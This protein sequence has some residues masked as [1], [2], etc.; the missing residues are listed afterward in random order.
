MESIGYVVC[1]T[2]N[3]RGIHRYALYLSKEVCN[4]ELVAPKRKKRFLWWEMVEIVRHC[5]KLMKADRVIFVNTRISPLLWPFLR[6]SKITV[7]VHDIMDTD[8][9]AKVV[10]MDESLLQ[11]CVRIARVRLN[12]WVFRYSVKHAGSVICNS[13]YTRENLAIWLD[14]KYRESTVVHP[15]LSFRQVLEVGNGRDKDVTTEVIDILAVAGMSRNKCVYDYLRWHNEMR[16]RT[17]RELKLTI[18]GVEMERLDEEGI[19]YINRN[20][21]SIKVKYGRS[22]DE[23]AKD[24]LDCSFFLSLSGE[25]GYGMPVADACSF[26]IRVVARSIGAFKEQ[27]ECERGREC[28]VLRESLEECV[29]E[30]INMLAWLDKASNSYFDKRSRINRYQ[31]WLDHGLGLDKQMM[32]CAAQEM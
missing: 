10:I 18:Y 3:G 21:D 22:S 6:W 26:G 27:K 31:K 24:Y 29:E 5:R 17:N 25:E 30:S 16:K 32:G 19:G 14:M 4:Y 1:S 20:G 9:E 28:L 15:P 2:P 13:R 23:L 11:G 8:G 7:V 12:S